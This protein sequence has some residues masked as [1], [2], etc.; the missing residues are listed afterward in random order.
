MGLV[1]FADH[2][3]PHQP[4]DF[5][6]PP[7]IKGRQFS[8]ASDWVASKAGPLGEFLNLLNGGS[9]LEDIEGTSEQ[10]IRE[11]YK[12]GKGGHNVET[13]LNYLIA[14]WK[15]IGIKVDVVPYNGSE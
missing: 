11:K 15:S 6:S 5:K 2:L 8:T 7:K 12:G 9:D 13:W 3:S 1:E 14:Y 4:G 10:H